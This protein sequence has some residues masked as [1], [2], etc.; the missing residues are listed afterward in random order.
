MVSVFSHVA[1]V[2]VVLV[3]GALVVRAASADPNVS[4]PPET[5]NASESPV[6]KSSIVANNKVT[7][8]DSQIVLS[9]RDR[10]QLIQ[11]LATAMASGA[12][13]AGLLGAK[14]DQALLPVNRD[15]FL[16]LKDDGVVRIGWRYPLTTWSIYKD[17]VF[18]GACEVKRVVGDYF[19]C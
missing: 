17:Y 15:A 7:I 8:Q 1:L 16:Y 6:M 12:A 14:D 10:K 13:A 4:K 3:A 19:Y 18:P 9:S 2:A 5:V 11:N